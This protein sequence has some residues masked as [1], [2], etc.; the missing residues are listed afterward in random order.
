MIIQDCLTFQYVT[1]TQTQMHL[2]HSA[3]DGSCVQPLNQW[4][5]AT[6]HGIPEFGSR[7]FSEFPNS[8]NQN[9]MGVTELL[10]SLLY[11]LG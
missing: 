1:K 5:N 6:N 10:A 3:A 2:V 4:H 7:K 9:I 8:Q 11:Q